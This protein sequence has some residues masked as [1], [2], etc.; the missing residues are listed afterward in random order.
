MSHRCSPLWLSGLGDWPRGHYKI[1]A[2]HS[3]FIP[4]ILAGSETRTR[5]HFYILSGGKS[6]GLRAPYG[7]IQP[8]GDQYGRRKLMGREECAEALQKPCPWPVQ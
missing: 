2:A 5:T 1:L 4:G 3:R 6:L 7:H 8:R